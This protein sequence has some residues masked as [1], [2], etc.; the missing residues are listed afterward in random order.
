MRRTREQSPAGGDH[1][2]ILPGARSVDAGGGRVGEFAA[3]HERLGRNRPVRFLARDDLTPAFFEP[4]LRVAYDDASLRVRS[5]NPLPDCTGS[6]IISELTGRKVGKL[7]GLIPLRLH[8]DGQGGEATTDVVVKAKPLDDEVLLMLGT[9]ASMCGARVTTAW[10]KHRHLLGF[11]GCHVRELAI[12]GQTDERFRRHVPRVFKTLGDDAREAYVV[13]LERLAG[14]RLMDSVD[15]GRRWQRRDID[16]ALR[17]I[18]QVHAIWMGREEELRRQPW[19]GHV[20][21]A[22]SMAA[23]TDLWDALAVHASEE[24]P[25]LLTSSRLERQRQLIASIGEWWPRLE[26]LPRTLIHNDFNPRNI[27]LR[28]SHGELTLCAYD[29]E[30]ATLHLPQHD[31]AELLAFVM[32]ADAPEEDVEYFLE[33]HRRS[34]EDA[35]GRPIDSEQW[36]EGYALALRDLCV[37]RFALYMLAHTF[38]QYTFLPRAIETLF[39][40][41][42]VELAHEGDMVP[43]AT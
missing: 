4:S 29:W 33:V 2:R 27:A 16:A 11:A 7:V 20:P 26:Q 18:G 5:V 25:A 8:H 6:S 24:F 13:V 35:S 17:G 32:P 22:R 23:M 36:R 39:H 19:L 42:D 14:L 43:C 41:L 10:A 31:L 40:L 12:Y 21:N 3:A 9:M 37:N 28:E 15:D 34:L 38:R 30:L 1:R